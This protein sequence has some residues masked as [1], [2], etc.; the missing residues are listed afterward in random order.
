MTDTLA[1]HD[2]RRHG[3]S[4]EENRYMA[5]SDMIGTEGE[6]TALYRDGVRDAEI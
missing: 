4:N 2:V 3:Q 5:K 6:I 1:P